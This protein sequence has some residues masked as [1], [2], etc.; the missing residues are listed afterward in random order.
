MDF[1]PVAPNGTTSEFNPEILGP[2]LKSPRIFLGPQDK[3]F[4]APRGVYSN[5]GKLLVADTGQ[6]RVFI[7]NQFPNGIYQEPDVVLGQNN[8]L[9]SGRN[10]GGEADASSLQYPTAIWTNGKKLI[11]ADAWNHRVLIWHDFPHTSG[12]AADVVLGQKDFVSNLPNETGVGAAPN[13][14]RLNW[15]YGVVSDGEKLWIA[16]TGNRRVLFF[17]KIPEQNFQA[18]DGLIGK[19]D[20]GDRDYSHQDAV[21]PYSVKLGPKGELAIADTQ[22]FRILLWHHWQN[23][24]KHKAEV[25]IGQQNFEENGANQFRLFPE[26]HTLNW[27]YDLCFYQKGLW[28]NDTANSRLL[29]FDSLPSSHNAPAKGLIGKRD[30][31]TSSENK[32]TL[33]GTQ[34]SLYWPFSIHVEQNQFFIADTGNH[35]IILGDLN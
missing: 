4:L 12:Q 19:K 13:A 23:A 26:A 22:F 6:N 31:Q 21:W 25:I 3:P 28:V 17:E 34:A 15:P 27:C 5:Q 18:A 14:S 35:R 32:E 20:F 11:V 9:G 24:F 29:W 10:A 33:N 7:W 2:M 30:F 16:D 8:A 1:L